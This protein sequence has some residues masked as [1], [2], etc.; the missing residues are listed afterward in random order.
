[1][2]AENSVAV[3]GR[4]EFTLTRSGRRVNSPVGHLFQF[5]DGKVVRYIN[6]VNTA[7]Y[8]QAAAAA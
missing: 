2:A 1:V 4:Y 6:L 7:D 5:R 3:F 8:L